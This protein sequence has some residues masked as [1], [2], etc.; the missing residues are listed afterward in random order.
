MPLSRFSS[1]PL[2]KSSSLIAKSQTALFITSMNDQ[3]SDY[4]IIRDEQSPSLHFALSKESSTVGSALLIRKIETEHKEQLL[5]A[6]HCAPIVMARSARYF[7][8]DDTDAFIRH[9]DE[10]SGLFSTSPSL[11]KRG[12]VQGVVGYLIC[13][14]MMC[15]YASFEKRGPVQGVV[16]YL[17]C[18]FMMLFARA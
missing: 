12:P 14:F 4:H 9:A 7:N 11:K 17:I 16:G 10:S 18:V 15:I 1:L 2:S 8:D 13:V 3:I 6:R 5:F